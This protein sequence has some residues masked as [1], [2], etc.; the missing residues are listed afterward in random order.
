MNMDIYFNV[1]KFVLSN[2]SLDEEGTMFKI[3]Q[4]KPQIM[5]NLKDISV[6]FD[7]YYNLTTDPELI[8]DIGVGTVIIDKL[9]VFGSGSPKIVHN[10]E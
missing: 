5:A 10:E 7:F 2:A 4:E 6:E 9:S 1:T 8:Q 3:Q